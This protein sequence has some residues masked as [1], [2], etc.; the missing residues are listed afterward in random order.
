MYF[1]NFYEFMNFILDKDSKN[2]F[3]YSFTSKIPHENV[4]ESTGN[5]IAIHLGSAP[6]DFAFGNCQK[7]VPIDPRLSF[8]PHFRYI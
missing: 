5:K 8:R 2:S 6:A 3:I 4:M 7:Y 1:F